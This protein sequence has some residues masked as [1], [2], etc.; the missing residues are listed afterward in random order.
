METTPSS[1]DPP[2]AWVSVP[3]AVPG[4]LIPTRTEKQ[5]LDW[6]LALA[7]QHIA[8]V[9]RALPDT[10]R[11]ALEVDPQDA[12][13]ALSTLRLYHR[14]NR[15]WNPGLAPGSSTFPFQWTIILWCLL[16]VM[17]HL[18]A[19]APG[20]AWELAGRFETAR[21]ATGEWWRPITATF[22]H[23]DLDH[24]VANLTSGFI[25][26]GLAFGRYGVGPS[27][28]LSLCAGSAANVL[29]CFLRSRDYIGLG[30]SGVVMAGLGMLAVSLVGEAREGNVSGAT[31]ARGLAGGVA[32]F[33]LLGTAPQSDVAAHAG[34]F[35]IGALL[36]WFLS[37]LPARLTR[38]PTTDLGCAGIYLAAGIVPWIAALG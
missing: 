32:L 23:A 24:L 34:G 5:A 36:A 3:V 29:A 16:L 13:R 2:H 17:L 27:L 30:A 14:E 18:A 22:L 9:I 25:V 12:G 38:N 4:V 11:W 15:H 1:G 33:L 10:S 28:L 7:S 21:F 26:L 31:A 20:S 37:L 8:C 6:S 19:D 35:V